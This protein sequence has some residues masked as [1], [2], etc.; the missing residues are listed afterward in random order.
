MLMFWLNDVFALKNGAPEDNIVNSDDKATLIKFAG[1]F[2]DKNVPLAI[3]EIE[4][5]I[6]LIFRNVNINLSLTTIFLKLRQ[7]F[8]D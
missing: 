3:S 8:I 5:G 2:G 6:T 7:I 4:N 1:A